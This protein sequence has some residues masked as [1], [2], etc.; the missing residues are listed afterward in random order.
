MLKGIVANDMN[1]NLGIG[2]DLPRLLLM[3]YSNFLH[4]IRK[5]GE[6]IVLDWVTEEADVMGIGTIA[7]AESTYVLRIR[8]LFQGRERYRTAV[9]KPEKKR[10]SSTLL[11]RLKD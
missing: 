7:R 11:D 6:D 4:C 10:K 9:L 5:T 2:I 3:G 8:F 1:G